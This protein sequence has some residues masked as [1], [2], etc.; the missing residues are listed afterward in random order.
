MVVTEKKNK[1]AMK[2]IFGI[3]TATIFPF[4]HCYTQNFVE[5]FLS[6]GASKWRVFNK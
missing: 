5:Y 6:P 2:N 4:F 3:R 1:L